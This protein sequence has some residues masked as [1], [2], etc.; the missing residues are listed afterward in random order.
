MARLRSGVPVV[1]L[2]TDRT[3]A[4]D[5]GGRAEAALQGLP[6]GSVALHLREKDLP[7]G[8]LLALARRLR[9]VCHAAGQA[10]LVND[11]LDVAL[12]AGADG[13][14]LPSAGVSPADARRLLGPGALVGVSCHGAEDVR[15]ARDGGASFAT[16]GPVH[17]TPSKRRYGVPVGLEALRG[18][19]ALGLPLVALGGIDAENAPAAIAA[20]AAGVAAIRAWLAGPDPAAAV[21]ALLAAA[22]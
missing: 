2:I 14:H 16:F 22:P 5:L 20:G 18:A 12:A 17:D 4:G 15:R 11:R 8:E 6:P 3:L 1:H 9:A 10:L 13:V 21:R 7:G 19:A